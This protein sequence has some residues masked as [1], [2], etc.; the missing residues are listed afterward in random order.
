[1]FPA[2]TIIKQK[3]KE[4]DEYL[5]L[6]AIKG[7]FAIDHVYSPVLTWLIIASDLAFKEHNNEL[8]SPLESVLRSKFSLCT[9]SVYICNNN[10]CMYYLYVYM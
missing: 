5:K 7:M 3:K 6:A 10:Q 1:M 8:V 9:V 4:E 2:E